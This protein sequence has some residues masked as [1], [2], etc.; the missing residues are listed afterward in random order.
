M[1]LWQIF[2]SKVT[3]EPILIETLAFVPRLIQLSD[4]LAQH[5]R[6]CENHLNFPIESSERSPQQRRRTKKACDQCAKSKSKCDFQDPCSRCSGQLVECQ[7][8]RDGPLDLYSPYRIMNSGPSSPAHK[9]ASPPPVES[10][11]PPDGKEPDIF[12]ESPA[13]YNQD[14]YSTSNFLQQ[15]KPLQS[16]PGIVTTTTSAGTAL[17]SNQQVFDLHGIY[18]NSMEFGS[19]NISLGLES[20]PFQ[21]F[22]SVGSLQGLQ[23]LPPDSFAFGGSYAST[24]SLQ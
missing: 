1:P 20:F 3:P 2:H 10:P 23:S 12:P 18:H 14:P 17:Y 7:Y 6:R 24:G 22:D 9:C 8:T 11:I 16:L 21:H 5:L 13:A 4:V 15:N 19:G